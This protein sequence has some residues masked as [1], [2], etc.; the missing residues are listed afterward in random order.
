VESER[1]QTQT[2][3][4]D[5]VMGFI[6]GD[7]A[8]S[9]GMPK[10]LP[11]KGF[12]WRLLSD[13]A[14]LE[15]GHTPS[16]KVSEYWDNGDVPWITVKHAAAHHGQTLYETEEYITELGELNSSARLLPANTVC[17]T[18]TG[19]LGFVV[20]T[21]I[22]MCTSQGLVNWVCGPEID[23]R[24]LKY[25]LLAESGSFH[26]F[27][28]G[29]AHQTIYF[30]EV[31]AFHALLPSL[32]EQSA[33]A[34]V[35]GALDDKIE[36]NRRVTAT[37]EKL[38]P[39]IFQSMTSE[40]EL[41]P[42]PEVAKLQ[43][44]ISYRSVDLEDSETA[45]VTLKSYDR[46]GG[47]K[48]NG[49]KPY[50]GKYKPEQVLLPGDMAVAQTDLTQG[51]EVVG[52]VIRIPRQED[53]ETLV[54]SLDLVIVRPLDAADKN[55]LYGALL[56]EDFREHCRSRTSGTTVLH[57]GSD[58]IPKYSIPWAEGDVRKV[59]SDEVQPLL[60]EH[61]SLTK[62]STSLKR[63]WDA[64]LPELLSGRLRVKDAESMMEN[65]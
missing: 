8:L 53:F 42:L 44:G 14:R 21:G 2:G 4:R 7:V 12:R 6:E 43:K 54:A 22:P 27:S 61:D 10:S 23:Y 51:A 1:R 30:P 31:K 52:R 19:S 58:A 18:R 41:K 11:P 39:L 40:S 63:L 59:F 9:V 26:R 38:V 33:I 62:E 3:G 17:L 28:W 47:Y 29:S 65:M 45:M 46:N 48:S 37:I 56:Q 24:Y 57:L 34:D 64:L 16:R 20:V 15:S 35:L 13:L 5:A 60:E 36:S 32:T 50:I 25:V 55:Y 49:L